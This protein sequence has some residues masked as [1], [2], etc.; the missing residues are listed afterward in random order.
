MPRKKILKNLWKHQRLCNNNF[1]V[2]LAFKLLLPLSK[3]RNTSQA[4][5]VVRD[6]HDSLP[7]VYMQLQSCV[8]QSPAHH[9]N[10]I[11]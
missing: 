6:T 10:C 1:Y 3:L 5:P 7:V 9:L 8:T 11:T 4:A 2:L